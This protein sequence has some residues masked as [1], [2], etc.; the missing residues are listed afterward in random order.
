MPL[1][2]S[3]VPRTE[4]ETLI[5]YGAII[6]SLGIVMALIDTCTTRRDDPAQG[7]DPEDE[8]TTTRGFW[9]D[10]R[11]FLLACVWWTAFL[12][13]GAIVGLLAMVLITAAD[14]YIPHEDERDVEAGPDTAETS[15]ESP[16]PAYS[17]SPTVLTES[18]QLVSET[19]PPPSYL[20]V[21]APDI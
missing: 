1:P 12:P 20:G 16:P 13:F 2:K 21:G 8:N 11:Y 15:G 19:S 3:P 4:Q 18:T 17:V 14:S 9:A 6:V 10:V 7:E 5:I